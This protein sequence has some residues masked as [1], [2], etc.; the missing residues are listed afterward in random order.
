MGSDTAGNG[1][2]DF[3]GKKCLITGAAS[4]IGRATALALA[5]RGAELYLTDRDEAG[6]TQTVADARALGAQVPAHRALDISDY[7]QVAAFAADVHAAHSSMDVV[8]NIAG[9][10]AWG[11]VDK[12]THQHWRSMIDVNLMGPIHVIETFLPPMVQARR[13]GHLVNVSSAAGIV[14]LPWHSAYSASKYGLRGL[15]EVLRFD[16][17]RHRIG[18]SVV[19]P[20]AVKTGL[21]QTV[22]IAGVDREDPNVQKWVDRFAGHAISPEQAA[23]KI[24][25][26][27]ARNRFLIYTS[28]D[29]RALYAFKRVAWW[30]YSVAMR[31]VNVL[32]SRALR[33]KSV[34]R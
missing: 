30:P 17:A 23:D 5:A 19:V 29:I 28:P 10:S 12:L 4:G 6:L 2:A 24:L 26:G 16:L 15:S 11:T 21:V 25:A 34:R 33:P 32:F 8:M 20:G 27:M 3:R 18:V 9:I 7:D 14:A 1:R 13:G 22:Q 31:Q